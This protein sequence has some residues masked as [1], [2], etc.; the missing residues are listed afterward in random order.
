[1]ITA[2]DLIAQKEFARIHCSALRCTSA[3]LV[4]GRVT[5]I[6]TVIKWHTSA[7]S[8]RSN[9]V[10]AGQKDLG[11]VRNRNRGV[12]VAAVALWSSFIA[13]NGT[14]RILLSR[15]KAYESLR[16]RGNQGV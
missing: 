16:S 15:G 5:A 3:W 13:C 14:N 1:M 7:A 12:M 9:K 10:S 8:C 2:M 4:I 6:S 11:G